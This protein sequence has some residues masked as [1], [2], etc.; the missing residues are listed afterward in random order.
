VNVELQAQSRPVEAFLGDGVMMTEK[1]SSP[2]RREEATHTTFN[3]ATFYIDTVFESCVSTEMFV[4]GALTTTSR[5]AALLS[6][7]KYI[8]YTQMVLL[9]SFAPFHSFT[10]FI[11]FNSCFS[12]FYF[13]ST[14]RYIGGMFVLGAD[15]NKSEWCTSF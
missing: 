9:V 2:M 11:F 5:N 8:A 13:D 10:A 4:M 1:R 15:C 6:S 7:S 3:L 14:M 12:L